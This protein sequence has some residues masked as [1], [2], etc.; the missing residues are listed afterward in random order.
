MWIQCWKLENYCLDNK[1]KFFN[2]LYN[3]RT[4][5]K[6]II[7][8]INEL[9]K[10]PI[11]NNYIQKINTSENIIKECIVCYE[12]KQNIQLSCKHEICIDC[13]CN[14]DRCYYHC[15]NSYIFTW[16]I[17]IIFLRYYNIYHFLL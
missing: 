7:D 8:K 13:Y 17:I 4:Q 14:V 16:N 3:L 1:L 2:L 5:E 11:I 10:N 15:E 12:T 6:I 9:Y